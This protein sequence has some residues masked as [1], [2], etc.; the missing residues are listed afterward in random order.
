MVGGLRVKEG[1]TKG[2]KGCLPGD[3][4]VKWNCSVEAA[5]RN[6]GLRFRVGA[7][8]DEFESFIIPRGFL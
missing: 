4:G 7:R 8:L 1:G 2:G 5:L 3:E 6:P